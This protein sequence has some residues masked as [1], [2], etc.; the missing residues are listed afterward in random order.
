MGIKGDK[1]TSKATVEAEKIVKELASLGKITSKK[2]F[3]GHGL[4]EDGA[5]FGLVNSEGKA[6]LKTDETT[7]A[8]FKKSKQH[9]KMP[10]YEIPKSIRSD[11]KDLKKLAK[12][13]IAISKK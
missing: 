13:A 3:G 5:M 6:Y 9:G 8:A 2:M 11:V 4:F 1:L 7:V 12:Q 10:Y